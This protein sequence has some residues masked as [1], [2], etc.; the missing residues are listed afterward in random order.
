[1]EIKYIIISWC[2]LI[3]SIVIISCTTNDLIVKYESELIGT[4]DYINDYEHIQFR[5]DYNG[6]CMYRVRSFS[7]Q[8]WD[9]KSGDYQVNNNTINIKFNNKE[10]TYIYTIEN[11]FLY[12]NNHI[13]TYKL[14][15]RKYQYD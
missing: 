15:K 2:V 9:I 8:M 7:G 13:I 3:I 4:W 6:K 12:L 14:T 11:D 10:T 1:M 5:F